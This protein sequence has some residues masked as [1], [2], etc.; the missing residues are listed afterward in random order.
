[1]V[2]FLGCP[3]PFYEILMEM[4]LIDTDKCLNMMNRFII[5]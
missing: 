4:I 3:K 2:R 1:M 5:F